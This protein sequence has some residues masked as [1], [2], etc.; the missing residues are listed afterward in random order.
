MSGGDKGKLRGRP[1]CASVRVRAMITGGDDVVRVGDYD[2]TS[3]EV[4]IGY[5]TPAE[6]PDGYTI[7]TLIISPDPENIGSVILNGSFQVEDPAPD[8]GT[9]KTTV[10]NEEK[11]FELYALHELKNAYA[12]TTPL[13]SGEEL[14]SEVSYSYCVE[15]QPCDE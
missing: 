3:M 11:M 8:T 12:G 4:T 15:G 9:F 2:I 13:V 10:T 5:S 14:L 6:S 7:D 1:R